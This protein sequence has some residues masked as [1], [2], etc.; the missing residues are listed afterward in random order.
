MA[1]TAA[2]MATVA[3]TNGLAKKFVKPPN[4]DCK[5]LTCITAA[6]KFNAA[7][8]PI[9]VLRNALLSSATIAIIELTDENDVANPFNAARVP[10]NV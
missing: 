6:L 1:A 7:F 2:P 10:P 8:K 5:S 9:N 4:W 3:I